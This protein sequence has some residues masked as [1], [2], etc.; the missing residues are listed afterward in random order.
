MKTAGYD[1]TVVCIDEPETHL[2]TRVQA[3]VLEEMLGLINDRSQLWI[4]THSIGMMRY[5]QR[6]WNEDPDAVAFLDFQDID[7]DQ[8]AVVKPTHLDRAFW[9][10]TLDV[11]LG[12]LASLIAPSRVVLCEGDPAAGNATRAEFDARCFRNIFEKSM[13]DTA[14]M[15]VGNSHEVEGDVLSVGSAITT[16]V[17]GTAA[18]R[19]V[20]RDLRTEQEIAE[21]EARGVKVLSRRH[22]ESFL[23]DDEVLAKLC[24]VH[25]QSEKLD[26][27]LAIKTE[28]IR[29]ATE[30]RGYDPDDIKRAA[31]DIYDKVRRVLGIRQPGNS[32]EAFLSDTLAPLLGPGMT[33][34]EELKRD[35]FA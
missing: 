23:L 20:D 27:V 22:L 13:P 31:G 9:A 32:R 28:A 3:A 14:F 18:I 24:E 16:L 10:R 29:A 6:A 17:T 34:Y 33:P 12:D 35:I 30:E 4:A 15:S 1:D 19:V 2:S 8:V 7:F 5:A 11:A 25:E 26:E 21:L